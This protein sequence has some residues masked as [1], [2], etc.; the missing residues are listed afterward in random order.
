MRKEMRLFGVVVCI[1]FV[2]MLFSSCGKSNLLNRDEGADPSKTPGKVTSISKQELEKYVNQLP[3]LKNVFDSHRVK[4]QSS[5]SNENEGFL[6]IRRIGDDSKLLSEEEETELRQSIYKAVGGEFPLNISVYTIGDQ[7]GLTGKIT[8]IDEKGRFLV[9]S[10]NKFLDKEMKM[11]EAAWYTMS[12]DA[13]IEFE[14]KPVHA[15]DVRIGSIVK[16]WSEGMMLTSYPGQTTGLRLEIMTRDNGI[17]DARGN[18]TRLEKT[19][20]GVNTERTIEV[21]GVKHR[22]LPITQVWVND[23]NAD[24]SDI[25][26]GESVKIWFAGY[27]IGPEKIV[28]QVVIER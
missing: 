7:P 19:G 11:P 3:L 10:S 27:E 22:L 28:T 1:L 9:V 18:V 17:G 13:N 2:T 6:E 8:A 20:E 16:V 4:F 25:E 21:D 12:D 5:Y 15:R 23:E 26:M 24:F 14:G